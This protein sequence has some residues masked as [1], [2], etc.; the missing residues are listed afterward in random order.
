M[1]LVKQSAGFLKYKLKAKTK[2]DIH[3]P[4]IYGL[5]T[6]VINDKT[7]H[8]C[9]SP[10]EK[11]RAKLLHDERIINVADLGAGSH[12]NKNTRRK[13]KDICRTA[14]KNKKYGQLLYRLVKHFQ[15]NTVIDLGTSLGITTLYL[16]R[17]NPSGKILT[18][19]GCPET[20]AIAKENFSKCEAGNIQATEGDFDNALPALLR[21]NPK[22]DFVFIDGNHRKI[23]TLNYF[24]LLLKHSLNESVF[25]FDD[26]NWSDE[27]QEAWK[28]IKKHPSVTVTIDLFFMGIIFFR[29]ELS[30]EE[31][32]IRF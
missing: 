16:S 29:K 23:P 30:K 11:L 9:Y 1:S 8:P 27:M 5:I 10:V 14:E 7:K 15:P 19:E 22:V 2:F 26:I 21:T 3:S 18:I 31:F 6:K 12:L 32:V 24:N 13:V 4:F 28:E 17:G 25:V 20:L